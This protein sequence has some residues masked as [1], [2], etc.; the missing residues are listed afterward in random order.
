MYLLDVAALRS[1]AFDHRSVVRFF[2]WQGCAVGRL[3][4]VV[5]P[6]AHRSMN[7]HVWDVYSVF[8]DRHSFNDDTH[9]DLTAM[10]G[11]LAAD[12]GLDTYIGSYLS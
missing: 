2:L 8:C 10:L 9:C 6:F 3:W 11:S 12:L 7:R 5:E 1:S 4:R